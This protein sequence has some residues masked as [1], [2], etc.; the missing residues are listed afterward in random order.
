MLAGGSL[1]VHGKN[2][3]ER[4]RPRLGIQTWFR[5]TCAAAAV[6]VDLVEPAVLL[7]AVG[8]RA[9]T[10]VGATTLTFDVVSMSGRATM[11]RLGPGR[12]C[13]VA[14][15]RSRSAVADPARRSSPVDAPARVAA[16]R[17]ALPRAGPAADT[18]RTCVLRGVTG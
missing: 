5:P 16:S 13:A 6:G 14:A 4:L 1:R 17:A 11:P 18:G 8:A 9:T 10:G 3:T 12:T 15:R 7:R 2:A